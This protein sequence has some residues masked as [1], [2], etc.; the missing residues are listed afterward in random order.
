M[1]IVRKIELHYGTDDANF[2]DRPEHIE[3]QFT[4]ELI[5]KIA[6]ARA[7]QAMPAARADLRAKLA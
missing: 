4:P 3:I 5:A 1:D 2:D 6:R 7:D